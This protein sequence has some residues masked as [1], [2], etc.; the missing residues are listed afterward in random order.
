MESIQAEDRIRITIIH[1][2]KDCNQAKYPLPMSHPLYER[3][4]KPLGS[5]E[6]NMGQYRAEISTECQYYS[7]EG[8][9]PA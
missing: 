1:I 8:P 7:L 3:V 2:I 9:D 4:E 5:D 6:E